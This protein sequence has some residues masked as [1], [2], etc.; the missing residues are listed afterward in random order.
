[1]TNNSFQPDDELL[2]AYIDGQ[3]S[4]DELRDVEEWLERDPAAR[5]MVDELRNVSSMVQSLPRETVPESWQAKLAGRLDKAT[6]SISES[7]G[8]MPTIPIG[9][10]SRGWWYSGAAIAAA[11]AIV[12]Y[13]RFQQPMA[14]RDVALK[15]PAAGAEV[16]ENTLDRLDADAN[17]DLGIVME[18]EAEEPTAETTTL[19]D[20]AAAPEPSSAVVESRPVAPPMAAAVPTADSD[21]D[22]LSLTPVTDTGNN[23]LIVWADVPPEALRKQ[24]INRVLEDNG[25]AVEERAVDWVTAAEPVRQQIELRSSLDRNLNEEA[26]RA[27]GFGGIGGRTSPGTSSRF[28]VPDRAGE[29]RDEADASFNRSGEAPAQPRG[30][31]GIAIEGETILV[32]AS[33]DQIAACLA[34]M[35]QDTGNYKAVTVEPVQ[36]DVV[37]EQLATLQRSQAT[38]EFAKNLADVEQLP[39]LQQNSEGRVAD[40][41]LLQQQAAQTAI[42]GGA[43]QVEGAQAKAQPRARRLARPNQW[44]YYNTAPQDASNTYQLRTA[45]GKLS[46]SGVVSKATKASVGKAE[47]LGNINRL[48]SQ[49]NARKPSDQPVIGEDQ[50]VHVLF[51]LRNSYLPEA[52]G[53][54]PT[55]EVAPAESP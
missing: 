41:R 13:T 43:E 30:R 5:A 29:S 20:L 44:Y 36:P 53:R 3:L 37:A 31:G 45:A 26:S 38:N 16:G 24:Q 28:S 54:V 47:Q 2:S 4:A 42:A 55:A 39:E 17:A 40:E 15:A 18:A 33:A 8:G 23:Y 21:G 50:Q 46:K 9:R 10:S 19:D 35:E 51:V 52:S 49:Q 6:T 11:V 48:L 34:E 32:E 22:S 27:S 12:C 7:G 25:I 14:P 1:M